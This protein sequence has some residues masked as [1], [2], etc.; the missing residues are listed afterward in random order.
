[1]H[2]PFY[3]MG[4]IGVSTH[5]K[6]YDE[7][8]KNEMF[9]DQGGQYD[10]TD[11]CHKTLVDIKKSCEQSGVICAKHDAN[12]AQVVGCSPVVMASIDKLYDDA[13]SEHAAKIGALDKKFQDVKQ[14]RDDYL[15]SLLTNKEDADLAHALL[16]TKLEELTKLKDSMPILQAT[17]DQFITEIDAKSKQLDAKSNDI[18]TIM[19]L[20]FKECN[21]D[22]ISHSPGLAVPIATVKLS[23]TQ[24]PPSLSAKIKT[25]V[26]VKK[27]NVISAFLEQTSISFDE[28]NG[29]DAS[30]LAMYAEPF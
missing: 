7:N 2:V 9:G 18:Q 28:I 14:K 27:E 17:C 23:T 20:W 19:E 5:L 22:T 11:I 6:Y 26:T 21:H 13:D 16:K 24:L 30:K 29:L 1:M 12:F 4:T 10:Y 8:T 25:I 3:I 15:A